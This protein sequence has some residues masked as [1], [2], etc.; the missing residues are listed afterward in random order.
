MSA[1]N[2]ALL[3]SVSSISPEPL[4]YLSQSDLVGL[5]AASSH[6]YITAVTQGLIQHAEGQVVQPIKPYLRWPEANHIADRIIAMPCYLGGNT[7]AAGIKWVGSREANGR[8]F[9]L[10]RASA[11]I[12]LNDV[13][14]NYPIAILEGSLIS[15]MRTAAVTA[16]AARYLAK[17]G[18][19]SVACV[20]CGPIAKMQI[21]TLIEQFPAIENIYLFDI[22][23]HAAE[24]FTRQFGE[25]YPHIH[26]HA[27]DSAKHAVKQGDV[28]VTCTVTDSPYIEYDWIKP[29]AFISNVSIMDVHKEVYERAD[30]VVVDD[31][32]QCNRE[33]KIINQLVLEGRFS[34][35]QLHAELGELVTNRKVGR[36][37]NEEIILLNAMGMAVDDI[38]CARHFYELAR[39]QSAGT[40]LSL[41]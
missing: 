34:K 19:K 25:N 28:V 5:G 18:F 1:Q 4:L 39:S 35:E 30:K 26:F 20:G 24:I 41:F 27:M 6:H 17:T 15:G 2:N 38:A 33:K 12:I 22:N 32:E 7:P 3:L 21:V 36:E 31:W 9:G 14:T 40:A 23:P 8:K 10:P 37:N 29:G 16:I 13:N 11:V